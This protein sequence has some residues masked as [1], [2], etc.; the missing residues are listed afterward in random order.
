MKST[1][2]TKRER[3]SYPNLVPNLNAKTRYETMIFDYLKKLSPDELSFLNRFM[4]EWVS[5]TF[6]KNPD[7]TYRADNF[8]KTEEERRERWRNNNHRNTCLYTIADATG[9]LVRSEDVSVLIDRMFIN[10]NED[11]KLLKLMIEIEE[12]G[13]AEA[14]EV[15]SD[16]ERYSDYLIAKNGNDLDRKILGEAYC[17]MLFK[18]YDTNLNQ[19]NN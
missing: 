18:L 16:K 10:C 14:I 3:V 7:N 19:E 13:G 5:G 15:D 4:G 6:Q 9:H 12:A 2:K 17:E 8:Y 1:K 11:D